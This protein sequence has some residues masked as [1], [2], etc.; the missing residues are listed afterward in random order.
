MRYARVSGAALLLLLVAAVGNLGIGASAIPLSE[1]LRALMAFDPD[2]LDHYVV[3]SQRLPRALIAIYV[4]A[5]LAAGGAVMQGVTGN[6]LASPSTLGVSAGA[7]LGMLLSV[8]VF[9]ASLPMQGFG[10]LAGGFAGFALTLAVARLTG[11]GPD[12][13][14]LPLILSGALTGILL[15]WLAGRCCLPILNAGPST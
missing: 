13:R 14:G 3:L 7:M 1:V 5:V 8:V 2:S 11:L 4:G 12:P 6:P 15:A 9:E 10:A